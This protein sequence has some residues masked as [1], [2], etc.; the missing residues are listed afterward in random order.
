MYDEHRHGSVNS[1]RVYDIEGHFI[2]SRVYT[3]LPLFYTLET[4]IQWGKF[5]SCPAIGKP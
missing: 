4:H 1:F 2:G 3:L 5:L